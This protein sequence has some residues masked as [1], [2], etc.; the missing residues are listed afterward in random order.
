MAQKYNIR[1]GERGIESEV[2]S[3]KR[4]FCN[5]PIKIGENEFIHFIHRSET[6]GL[7][8][9]LNVSTLLACKK[10]IQCGSV[11]G[12]SSFPPTPISNYQQFKYGINHTLLPLT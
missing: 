2:E 8:I 4:N 10:V 7:L 12:S 3:D 11:G 6:K 5:V 9:K 1:N